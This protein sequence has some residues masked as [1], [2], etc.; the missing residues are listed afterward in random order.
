MPVVGPGA[1]WRVVF[2]GGLIHTAVGKVSG[3]VLETVIGANGQVSDISVLRSVDPLVD[4]AAVAAARQWIYTPT[5][6]DGAAVP[7]IMTETVNFVLPPSL[8]DID[9]RTLLGLSMEQ[10]RARVGAPEHDDDTTWTY[11]SAKGTVTRVKGHA[12]MVGNL[13]LGHLVSHWHGSTPY[14][15]IRSRRGRCSA[16]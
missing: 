15:D 11:Q 13:G 12:R 14:E 2:D 7:V 8:D 16:L 9:P 3:R 1:S 4:A 10:V 5:V 6:L